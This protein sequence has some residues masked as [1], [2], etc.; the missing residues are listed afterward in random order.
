MRL[1]RAQVS[2]DFDVV[3]KDQSRQDDLAKVMAELRD[4]YESIM[5]KNKQEQERWFSSQVRRVPI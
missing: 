4:Q 1:M 3:V 2:R 5:I